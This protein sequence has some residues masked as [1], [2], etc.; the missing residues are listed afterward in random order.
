M[1]SRRL[2]LILIALQLSLI[3]VWAKEPKVAK[4]PLYLHLEE[5]HIEQ[6]L[7]APPTPG[8]ILDKADHATFDETR[9]R[10]T[11]EQVEDA[12]RTEHDSVFLYSA[13]LGA[14]FSEDKLPKTKELFYQA[15]YDASKFARVPKIQFHRPRPDTPEGQEEL[16][17]EPGNT[18]FSFPSAHSTRAYVWASLLEQMFPDQ[19]E[20]LLRYA[21]H[22]AWNRVIYG[23]HFPADVLAGK[24]LGEF[25]ANELLAN[26][27]F[28]K[29]WAEARAELKGFAEQHR[30]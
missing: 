16:A 21:H 24:V 29:A 4:G 1:E 26:P 6:I 23:K 12:K 9:A 8:S 20:E 17:K 15:A 2:S 3:A 27:E 5:Y 11:P 13:V 25:T 19:S 18:N 22:L 14:D 7:P 10:R 28:Q 30:K